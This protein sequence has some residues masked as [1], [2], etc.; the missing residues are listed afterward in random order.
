MDEQVEK[1]VKL[2]LW[3]GWIHLISFFCPEFFSHRALFYTSFISWRTIDNWWFRVII[4]VERVFFFWALNGW[5]EVH[6]LSKAT[7]DIFSSFIFLTRKSIDSFEMNSFNNWP[8]SVSIQ[9]INLKLN[10]SFWPFTFLNVHW[11][12]N[13]CIEHANK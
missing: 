2:C 7:T 1:N 10:I 9:K 13:H 6:A 3:F 8:D 5:N 12:S 4:K 11:N